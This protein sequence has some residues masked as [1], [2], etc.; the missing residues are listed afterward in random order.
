MPTSTILGRSYR[1]VFMPDGKEWMAEN[2]AY[3]GL[4]S[5]WNNAASDDGDGRYYPVTDL[6][7]LA[8]LLTAENNGWHWPSYEELLALRTALVAANPIPPDSDDAGAAIKANDSSWNEPNQG[9][10]LDRYGF[11]LRGSGSYSGQSYAWSGK[12]EEGYFQGWSPEPYGSVYLHASRNV[13]YIYNIIGN[14]LVS[15][16][17]PIRLVRDIQFSVGVPHNGQWKN[18][19]GIY[20]SHNG[21]WKNSSGIYVSHNGQWVKVR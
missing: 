7:S 16:S 12:K 18:A 13:A 9:S 21:Q 17:F 5:Y 8:S 10:N 15:S 20:V 2:L 3:T 6:N 4:G 11:S 14:N 1:T 19:S